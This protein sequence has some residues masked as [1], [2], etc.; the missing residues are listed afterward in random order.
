MSRFIYF[1]SIHC[2]LNLGVKLRT[3]DKELRTGLC[4]PLCLMNTTR[5]RSVKLWGQVQYKP[6]VDFPKARQD[7]AHPLITFLYLF[8]ASSYFVT[9]DVECR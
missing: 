4:G 7:S 9:K 6:G 3:S 8:H 2:P 5:R 1:T